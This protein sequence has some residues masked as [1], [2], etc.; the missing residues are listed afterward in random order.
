MP[1]YRFGSGSLPCD[2]RLLVLPNLKIFWNARSIKEQITWAKEKLAYEAA[3]NYE[4]SWKSHV[5]GSKKGGVTFMESLL[6]IQ[7]SLVKMTYDAQIQQRL[8]SAKSA[9]ESCDMAKC[10]AFCSQSCVSQCDQLTSSDETF[11]TEISWT[12]EMCDVESSKELITQRCNDIK[13]TS[14][15]CDAN[16]DKACS[17]IVSFVLAFS[18]VMLMTTTAL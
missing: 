13:S 8:V 15:D 11:L 16:C 12:K 1:A 3:K 5:L 18:I 4:G 9:S 6:G 2:F 17:Q 14:S 7:F 10:L